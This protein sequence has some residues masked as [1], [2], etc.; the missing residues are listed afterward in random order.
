MLRKLVYPIFLTCVISHVGNAAQDEGNVSEI[1]RPAGGN[2]QQKTSLVTSQQNAFSI[3][4]PQMATARDEKSPSLDCKDRRSKCEQ[5]LV[6]SVITGQ[7]AKI[8]GIKLLSELGTP[9]AQG[10]NRD[11]QR[12]NPE[13]LVSPSEIKSQI[14]ATT[15]SLQKAGGNANL[16]GQAV[17][18]HHG[19]DTSELASPGTPVA[20]QVLPSSV[21]NIV[22]SSATT[23]I[24]VKLTLD[25]RLINS[26]GQSTVNISITLN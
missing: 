21:N 17:S 3:H 5:W 19:P 6:S 11:Q 18:L 14:S 12:I 24:E 10:T 23:P 20:Q 25:R 22:E 16:N 2:L 13:E 8:R 7:P 26:S 4:Q 15:E 1:K 9:I